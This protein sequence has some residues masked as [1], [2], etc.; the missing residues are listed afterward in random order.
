MRYELLTTNSEGVNIYAR[1][2]DDGLCRV[3]CIE[4]NFDYQSWLN[5]ET[6]HSAEVTE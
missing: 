1:I 4:G 3:T 6:E 2:D 5:P